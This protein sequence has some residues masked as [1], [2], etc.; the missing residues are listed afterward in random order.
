MGTL[1]SMNPAAAAVY[2]LMTAGIA[3]FSMNPVILTL[4]LAGSLIYFFSRGSTDNPKSHLYSLLLFI[5]M[6]AV[7]PL[8]NHNGATVLFVMN[9]N[10]VTFEA[11]IYG[12][13]A[14]AMIISVL[15]WFRSFTAI[16]TSDKLLYIFG[17]LSPKLA[18]I[19]S[20]ALRFVPMFS[21]QIKKTEQAQKAMG[22][23]KENNIA[24][25]FKGKTNIFSIIITWGLENGIITADSMTARGYGCGRRSGFSVFRWRKGDTLFLI[26][27][28]LLFSLTVYGLFNVTFSYYPYIKFSG[29]SIFAVAGYTAYGILVILPSVLEAKEALRWKYLKSKI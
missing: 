22:L 27:A 12:I 1:N 19:L 17:R 3:M 23:Y 6:A 15:Y 20:M 25:T 11:L 14:S 16:M 8:V 18:L 28:V 9:D 2:F 21:R 4:S 13:A 10:P 7:N 29:H 26:I 24:D 5:I